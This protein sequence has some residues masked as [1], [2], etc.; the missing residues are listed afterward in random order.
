MAVTSPFESLFVG[1]RPTIEFDLVDQ[2]GV[3]INLTGLSTGDIEIYLRLEGAANNLYTTPQTLA[4]SIVSPPTAG[5]ITYKFPAVLA[6]AGQY[7]GQVKVK[8]AVDNI[9][10]TEFFDVLV[11]S[12]ISP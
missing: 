2:D 6:A 8:F 3:P 10:V 4:T 7:K 11:R 12:G 1:E 5:R 9:R